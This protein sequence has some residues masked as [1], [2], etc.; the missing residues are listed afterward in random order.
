MVAMSPRPYVAIAGLVVALL[1]PS[2][3]SA[4]HYTFQDL[5]Q[6]QNGAIGTA[7]AT[8]QKCGP[9]GILGTYN[10]R[11]F[12]GASGQS[13]ELDFEV[14]AGLSVRGSWRPLKRVEVDYTATNY[15]ADL[16]EQAAT[17]LDQFHETV[18]TKYKPA[19]QGDVG[20]LLVRHGELVMFGNVVVEPDESKTKFDPKPGC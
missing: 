15:P 6:V 5:F 8:A 10:Y 16:A 14:H 17:A 1:V 2:T 13:F 11:S 3:A 19:K 20:K 18:Y 12:V 7:R 4:W 9:G